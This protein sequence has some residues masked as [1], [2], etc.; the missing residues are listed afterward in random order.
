MHRLT[1]FSALAVTAVAAVLALVVALAWLRPGEES[2]TLS[3]SAALFDEELV[4]HIYKRVSPAVVVVRAD[5]KSG[6]SFTP[7]ASGSGFLVDRKGHIATNNHVI[8][9]AD[10]VLV[11]F[12]SGD[13]TPVE[14]LGISPGNDLA[15]LKVDPAL[16]ANIQP[17]SLGDSSQVQPGQMAVAIGS[18]FGLGGSITVGVV[19]GIDRVLGND[20]ARPVHG[21]LQTNAVTNPG[22]SG[23]PLLDRGG[24]V[25]GINTAV[26]AGPLNNSVENAN[27]RIGFAIPINTLVRLLPMLME[28][29]VIQPNLLGIAATGVNDLLAKRL[30]LPV[31]SGVYVAMVILDSPAQ[32]AGLIP[33][34]VSGR[35]SSA[36]GD[37]IV[38]VDGVP[39]GSTAGFF[40]ELD[41]HFPGE[42]V[43]LSVI[44]DRS[45]IEVLVILDRW[46]EE[47]NPF[48][49]STNAD[50][51]VS[52]GGVSPYPFVPF[53]P[54]FDFP[55]LFP[56]SPSK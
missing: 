28:K 12:L 13:V 44:R 55:Q 33:A 18:P 40:A 50:Q 37:V 17:A 22:D 23:G 9:G 51:W 30:N 4:Q 24:N 42:K 52:D 6:D 53:V 3:G 14:V 39:V 34:G 21:I 29:Q 48:T 54:G 36:G 8:Q 47:G 49:N 10:Q 38:A 41:R 45:N 2:V 11:E 27:K 15:L 35:G 25:I 43:A 46:P 31:R 32:R 26:Q 16:V 56:Q 1:K 20:V 19:G 7:I 5:L